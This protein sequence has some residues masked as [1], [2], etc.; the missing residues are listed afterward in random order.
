MF[1]ARG[2][3]TGRRRSRRRQRNHGAEPGQRVTRKDRVTLHG[4]PVAPVREY[5]YIMLHKPRGYV[6]TME[7][8]HAKKKAVDLIPLSKEIRIVSV[9]RLDKDSEGLLLFSNDGDFI[10]RLTHPRYE[11]RKI[12]QVSVEGEI[13]PVALHHLTNDGIRDR[14]DLLKAERIECIAPGKYEFTLHEGKNREVR[15]MLEYCGKATRR[16]KRVA[17]GP[18]WTRQS[19]AGQMAPPDAAGGPPRPRRKAGKNKI[20]LSGSLYVI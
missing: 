10:A 2:G 3:G 15:R 5:V 14:G 16:L 18:A 8:P 1:A 19:P 9:G 6:C 12:Y 4:K 11:V 17:V 7:D 13:D 20:T